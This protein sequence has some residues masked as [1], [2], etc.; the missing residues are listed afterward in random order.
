MLNQVATHNS[1]SRA[2]PSKSFLRNPS[3]MSV[4]ACLQ[5][6]SALSAPLLKARACNQHTCVLYQCCTRC[7]SAITHNQTRIPYPISAL[8]QAAA[9]SASRTLGLFNALKTQFVPRS[10]HSVSYENQS[11]NVV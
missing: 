2:V 5:T 7:L 1:S 8:H 3:G 6:H 10:K 11:V 9:K 4:T